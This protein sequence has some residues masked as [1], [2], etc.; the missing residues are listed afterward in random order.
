MH[1][2][3]IYSNDL[4]NCYNRYKDFL[5]KNLDLKFREKK[6]SKIAQIWMLLNVNMN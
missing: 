6:I 4:Q 1:G 3:W 5:R 2:S